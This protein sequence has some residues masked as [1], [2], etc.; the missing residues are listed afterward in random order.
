MFE[1]CKEP[2]KKKKK[3]TETI[4]THLWRPEVCQHGHT[5]SEGSP[6]SWWPGHAL[7]FAALLQPLPL[8]LPGLLFCV[9]LCAFSV[10]PKDALIEFRTHPNAVQAHLKTLILIT[11]TKT[12][13]PNTVTS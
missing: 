12:F 9:S 4:L 10:S 5:P 8:S 13:F 2:K 3:T 7:A 1:L 6:G 11:S